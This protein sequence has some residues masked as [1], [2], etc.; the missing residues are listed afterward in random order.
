MN[1]EQYGMLQVEKKT[2][3]KLYKQK[4]KQTVCFLKIHINKNINTE[5][6]LTKYT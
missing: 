4:N 5:Y 1:E 2:E 3:N 6:R